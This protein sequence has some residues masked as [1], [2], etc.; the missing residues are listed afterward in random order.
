MSSGCF[1]VF[2][3]LLYFRV[4]VLISDVKI[5]MYLLLIVP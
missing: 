2:V 4:K 5:Q 1:V 3:L